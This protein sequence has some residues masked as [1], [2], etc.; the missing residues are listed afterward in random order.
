MKLNLAYV[1][2]AK[3]GNLQGSE[4]LRGVS[5]RTAAA[6]MCTVTSGLL[7]VILGAVGQDDDKSKRK[8]TAISLPKNHKDRTNG[9]SQ[10]AEDRESLETWEGREAASNSTSGL[11]ACWVVS[12]AHV[13]TK[14]QT[15]Y[16][17]DCKPHPGLVNWLQDVNRL[18]PPSFD[19]SG[20]LVF[21]F[22]FNYFF[23]WER[24]TD[25]VHISHECV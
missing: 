9:C 24:E 15:P 11:Y 10:N 18:V 3:Q 20:V 7:V 17:T 19:V 13:V 4:W 14:G 6:W 2:P 22:F 8:E 23:F 25:N 21:L 1:R 5:A 12:E 16:S